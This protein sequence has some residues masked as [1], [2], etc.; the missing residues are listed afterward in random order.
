MISSKG[1]DYHHLFRL[2]NSPET[3]LEELNEII[4][5]ED[6]LLSASVALN[7]NCSKKILDTLAK[8]ESKEV[9]SNLRKRFSSYPNLYS[10]TLREVKETDAEYIFGLRTDKKYS[11]Y[12]SSVSNEVQAQRDYISSYLSSNAVSRSSFFFIME[13][14]GTDLRCGTVRIYNFSHNCFEW[15][16]WILDENKSRFAAMETAIFVYEFAFNN[17]GFEKS[18]FE[19]NRENEKV[20]S[21][22]LKSGAKIIGE[23]EKN[24]YFRITKAEGLAFAKSLRERL[25]AKLH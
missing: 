21:Y 8:S 6:D 24:Y 19:V 15:G 13:N 14:K 17:L 22:H 16:S 2:A 12:I 9:Q 18:E 25:E 7:P 11:K 23:D 1:K 20:I 5:M 10:I 3:E 4:A